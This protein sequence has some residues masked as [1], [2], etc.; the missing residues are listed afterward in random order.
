MKF[1]RPITSNMPKRERYTLYFEALSRVIKERHDWIGSY[2]S[3]TN[4][5]KFLHQDDAIT[6]NLH[7]P[8][9]F[10]YTAR[11]PRGN[12]EVIAYLRIRDN[13]PLFDHLHKQRSE[14][15]SDFDSA[16]DWRAPSAH[17]SRSIVL[18]RPGSIGDTEHKLEEYG[19]WHI[20]TLLKLNEAFTP[21]IKRWLA[22]SQMKEK[23]Y[24]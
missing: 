10:C 20:E 9:L 11:F 19:E 17:K 23:F 4:W 16:P 3:G 7:I 21:R 15:D 18:I 14:I 2:D 12:N 5:C 22:C 24:E 13:H 6:F 1:S 8:R